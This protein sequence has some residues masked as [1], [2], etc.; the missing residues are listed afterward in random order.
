MI[1]LLL[2]LLLVLEI[3]TSHAADLYSD[4]KPV[5]PIVI[6]VQQNVQK[7]ELDFFLSSIDKFIIASGNSSI[8]IKVLN[9]EAM[10]QAI[11]SKHLDLVLIDPAV[12]ATFEINFGVKAL[13]SILPQEATSIQSVAAGA[14]ITSDSNQIKTLHEASEKKLYSF[15]GYLASLLKFDLLNQNYDVDDF[16]AS[17]Q[18]ASATVEEAVA[19]VNADPSAIALIPACW[20][21]KNHASQGIHS[22]RIIEPRRESQFGCQQTTSA[23]PGWTIARTI[24]S[25]PDSSRGLQNFLLSI[26]TQ[27]S[28]LSWAPPGD[29]RS[30][31]EALEKS[32]DP[33]Y[34]KSRYPSW[35]AVLD[36]YR[37]LILS[38]IGI[39]I[40]LA[41]YGYVV[42]MLVGR[43]GRE[44]LK[45]LKEKELAERR[46]SALER[47]S[48]VGQM[49]S[50]VA[51]ELRQPL[52][53]IENYISSLKR[54]SE[55]KQ[56]DEDS[57]LFALERISRESDR[58]NS[59]IEHV[60]SYARR[61]LPQRRLINL[62][63]AIDKSMTDV[64][65]RLSW[66]GRIE[67][68]IEPNL[69]SVFDELELSLV[70]SNLIK[71]S[72][73]A[74]QSRDNALINVSLKRSKP[75]FIE[76]TVEDNGQKMTEQKVAELSV[77]LRSSKSDGLG[78]GLAIVRRIV[79]G[80]GGEINFHPSDPH[81]L[82]VVVSI[83][84]AKQK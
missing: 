78:L 79:E 71:N 69:Y 44:L 77:P 56:L 68:N 24:S 17:Q 63:E 72:I 31:R 49:S 39:I 52:A 70:V 4:T 30:L 47:V 22:I 38:V 61:N 64:Q 51:H 32:E 76:F 46:F 13:A 25:D 42:S 9:N 84:E 28:G 8:T 67:L 3:G 11:K 18:P 37:P 1:R 82:K 6:G 80:S 81:G 62:S 65:S 55:R 35:K 53:A 26:P 16:F 60:R 20:L 43:K 15:S 36:R 21:E 58:A 14:L 41:A 5:T 73:E 29:Y 10:T 57:L 7:R 2:H 33:F 75:G 50:V 48:I 34:M 45:V 54:R 74:T 23:Y 27:T 19:A 59:I 83:M 66:S 12:F 40:A